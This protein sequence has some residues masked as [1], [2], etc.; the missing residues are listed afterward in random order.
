MKKQ[1][2][3]AFL[4]IGVIVVLLALTA[5]LFVFFL[6]KAV[7]TSPLFC[8]QE[9]V[10]NEE[11][12]TVDLAHLKGRNI[13]T[14]NLREEAEYLGRNYT[15]YST[16]R[17][18]RILPNRIFVDFLKRK[19]VAQVRLSRPFYVDK[20]GVLFD[21]GEP[22]AVPLIIGLEGK[23][24]SPLA[25]RQYRIKELVRALMFIDEF[26]GNDFLRTFSLKKIVVSTPS[27]LT[28]FM[29]VA[30]PLAYE[31]KG[32]VPPAAEEMEV[33]IDA[34]TIRQKV[35]LLTNVLRHV[36]MSP[37]NISYIDLR[38]NDPVVK[39]KEGAATSR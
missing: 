3:P 38:F 17:I 9:V 10:Y 30:V 13:F 11:S 16:V 37:A 21:M 6:F 1:K 8:I 5:A 33:R 32:G 27:V 22:V 29:S 2:S 25:G 18:V 26:N 31:G 36:N 7:T 39:F 14:V 4:K 19:P 24:P 15:S 23:I 34:N 20:D 35:A 28:V 12:G